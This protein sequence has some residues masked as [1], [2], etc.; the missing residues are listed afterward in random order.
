MEN[1]VTD[2]AYIIIISFSGSCYNSDFFNLANLCYY[3]C[4]ATLISVNRYVRKKNNNNKRN[5]KW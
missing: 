5:N 2:I 4:L 3:V 1:I